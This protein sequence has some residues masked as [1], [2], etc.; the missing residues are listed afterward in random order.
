[1]YYILPYLNYRAGGSALE[2]F[3]KARKS[4]V[5]TRLTECLIKVDGISTEINQSLSSLTL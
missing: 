4:E 3:E 1:M 2:D 5:V